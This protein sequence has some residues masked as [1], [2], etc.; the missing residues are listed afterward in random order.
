M[1][2]MKEI[3]AEFARS[4]LQLVILMVLQIAKNA[5]QPIT[6]LAMSK[7]VKYALCAFIG[8]IKCNLILSSIFE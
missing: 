3:Y 4:H 7:V 5:I 1:N 8:K 2:I 6:Q